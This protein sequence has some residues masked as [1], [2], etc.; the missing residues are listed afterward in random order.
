M[1]AFNS[2][3]QEAEVVRSLKASLVYRASSKIVKA[4]QRN[5]LKKLFLCISVCISTLEYRC[6]WRPEED[7][8]SHGAAG[9]GHWTFQ[10]LCIFSAMWVLGTEPRS[11]GRAVSALN[12]RL[13]SPVPCV[14]FQCFIYLF[15]LEIRAQITQAG[16]QLATQQK[17]LNLLPLPQELGLILED[18][19]LI[20]R[21]HIVA[22]NCL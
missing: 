3:V 6:L 11:A 20:P 13:I 5:C 16:F 1:Q 18:L 12:C 10:F 14:S 8:R 21:T 7:I 9:A 19:G 2:S 17:L 22:H 15:N 4:I